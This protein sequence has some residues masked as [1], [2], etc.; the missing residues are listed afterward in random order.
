MN[1]VSLGSLTAVVALAVPAL[2]AGPLTITIDQEGSTQ[3]AAISQTGGSGNLAGDDTHPIQQLGVYNTLTITQTGNDNLVGL[4][5]GGLVQTGTA[6]DD[7]SFSNSAVI[8]QISDG[9]A[10][11]ALTQ[12]SADTHATTS[13][14]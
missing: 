14:V 4:A 5:Y 6:S 12:T 7:G 2:G 11:G 1:K 8:N 3:N 10:L 9:N 13:N